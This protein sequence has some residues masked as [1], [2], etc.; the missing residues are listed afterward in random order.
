MSTKHAVAVLGGG[1]WGSVLAAIATRH[2]H[3]V[4]VWEIDRAAADALA[5]DRASRG[6]VRGFRPPAEIAVSCDIGAAISD[7]DMLVVAVPSAFVAATMQAVAAARAPSAAA[8][9]R[10]VVCASK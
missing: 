9:S 7:R 4:A 5:R 3:D 1:A 10:V 6:W 2:G 8:Q